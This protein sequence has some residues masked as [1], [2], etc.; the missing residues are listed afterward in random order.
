MTLII[1]HRG[2]AAVAPEN[3]LVSFARAFTDGADGVEFD[4]QL[5]GD[6]VP[7]V[8]H[9]D[10][11]KRTALPP[12]GNIR[13]ARVAAFTAAKLT[14]IDVGSRF[15]LLY[16]ALAHESFAG[17]TIPTLEQVFDACPRG[18]LYVELKC[19]PNEGAELA[20]VVAKMV[21][22]RG[23]VERVVIESFAH[24]AIAEVKRVA[25]E[26]R[27]AA[28][29]DVSW[30]NLLAPAEKII[31]AAQAVHANEIAPYTL[32]TTKRLVQLARQHNLPTVIWTADAPVWVKRAERYGIH[33]IITNNPARMRAAL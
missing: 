19:E 12:P 14:R 31:A 8:I 1:G 2:A 9:D 24:D 3:T 13:W 26:I 10:T 30:R 23:L 25:P 28:L 5:S 32:L 18:L 17:A 29:F 22:E 4:V 7:V 33:A 21:R 11:P 6:G 27:A 16:P 20:R 15:N